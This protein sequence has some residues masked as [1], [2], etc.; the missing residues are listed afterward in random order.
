MCFVVLR[1]LEVLRHQRLIK[2]DNKADTSNVEMM[3]ERME[4]KPKRNQQI[5]QDFFFDTF[6]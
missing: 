2:E 5:D 3:T 1:T 4:S 6:Q